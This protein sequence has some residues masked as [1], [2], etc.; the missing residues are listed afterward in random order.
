MG[1]SLETQPVWEMSNEVRTP[2]QRDIR[3]RRE[4]L[5][6]FFDREHLVTSKFFLQTPETL[7]FP[8]SY[9]WCD[10]WIPSHQCLELNSNTP[11]FAF[12]ILFMKGWEE[13]TEHSNFEK[14]YMMIFFSLNKSPPWPI[15]CMF[16]YTWGLH[17]G[18][19]LISWNS[20]YHWVLGWD[21]L[22]KGK[23]ENL[24]EV[25]RLC[26]GSLIGKQW[27]VNK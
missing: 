18:E 16:C 2:H 15:S 12:S 26:R 8:W 19:I 24:S 1:H 20:G 9:I 4:A 11:L 17:R 14:S 23:I 25:I 13:I 10:P 21:I 27:F 5:G 7:E 22:V 6:L 3:S